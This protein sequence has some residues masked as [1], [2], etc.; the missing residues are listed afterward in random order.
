MQMP[1]GANKPVWSALQAEPS[2]RRAGIREEGCWGART[3][4][5]WASF[6][7]AF[8]LDPRRSKDHSWF[9]GREQHSAGDI[10]VWLYRTQEFW[11][12]RALLKMLE[13]LEQEGQARGEPLARLS[14]PV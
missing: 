7:Q 14:F 8:G 4:S 3:S 11:S 1:Q 13:G 2:V 5:E 10:E 6:I 9:F 12:A